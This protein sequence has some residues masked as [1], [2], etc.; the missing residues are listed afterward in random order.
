MIHIIEDCI[1]DCTYAL[2]IFNKKNKRIHIGGLGILNFARGFYLY[3]GSA[4]KNITSRLKR[5]LSNDKKKFW[6]IDYFLGTEGVQIR[7][8]W[9]SSENKECQ[10][11]QSFL[12]TGYA[13]IKRF[14]SS[15]CQCFSH[16]FF[17]GKKTTDIK[18]LLKRNRF[19]NVY[20]KNQR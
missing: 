9:T 17:A 19:K 15:D 12:E 10:M 11:A 4:K 1:N 18:N 8:I 20:I 14:G 6:H 16:L 3:L 7:E 2:I 5:H 13:C